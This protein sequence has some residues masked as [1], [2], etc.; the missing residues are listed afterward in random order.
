MRAYFILVAIVGGARSIFV[1]MNRSIFGP[2]AASVPVVAQ[3]GA[4]ID[5][6]FALGFLVAGVFLTKLLRDLPG[7]LKGLLFATAGMQILVGGI[8]FA[9]VGQPTVLVV[10][11]IGLLIS[12]YL[13]INVYRLSAA[14]QSP[15]KRPLA[16]DE[17]G[18]ADQP[19]E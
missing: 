8:L 1:L 13:L 2:P 18:V 19:R 9:S 10:P 16:H 3:V 17:D 4:G 6:A 11:A 5:L 15:E 12:L 14:E 7:L